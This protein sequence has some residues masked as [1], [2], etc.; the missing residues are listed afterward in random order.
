MSHP[1]L[2]DRDFWINYWRSTT[3]DPVSA[4]PF[5][6]KWLR[7]FPSGP[8][9]FVE[10]GGFP[11]SYSAY[12]KKFLGYEVTLLDFVVDPEV[13]QR[14]EKIN[15]IRAGSIE[16]IQA[17]FVRAEVT[18]KFDVVFSAGFIEHFTDTDLVF[19]KHCDYLAKGGTLFISLPNFKGISGW[20]QKWVDP[21]NYAAHSIE[22]MNVDLMRDLCAHHGLTP[23]FVGYD[24]VPHVWLDHPEKSSKMVGRLVDLL[25]TILQQ[26]RGWIKGKWIS[27]FI[28]VVAT[29]SN[30]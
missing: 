18:R 1:E 8:V 10:I 12:F 11:G 25:S 20:I 28:I 9:R 5:F 7:Y 3:I 14:V 21:A 30:E 19:R 22:S 15:E 16:V 6:K 29:K 26:T 4:E 23:H 27:P 13:I 24:G 2:T 17:D